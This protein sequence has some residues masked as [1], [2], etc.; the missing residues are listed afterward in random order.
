MS[1]PLPEIPSVKVLGVCLPT[2]PER[3]MAI[4]DQEFGPAATLGG[5]VFRDGPY[6]ELD[7][8]AKWKAKYYGEEIEDHTGEHYVFTSCPWCGRDLPPPPDDEGL[9]DEQADGC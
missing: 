8:A 3:L 2:C 6:R 1:N 7:I 5:W 4:V 9:E